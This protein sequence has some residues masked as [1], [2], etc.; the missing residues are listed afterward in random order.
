MQYPSKMIDDQSEMF[1]IEL[2]ICLKKKHE[3]LKYKS[4]NDTIEKLGGVT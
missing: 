1:S 4:V 3:K 2:L